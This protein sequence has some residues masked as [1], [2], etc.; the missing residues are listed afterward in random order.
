MSALEGA[1]NVLAAARA[2][3][4]QATKE[5]DDAN[6]ALERAGAAFNAGPSDEREEECERCT[7]AVSKAKRY[8]EARAKALT[9]ATRSYEQQ[10]VLRARDDR[11]RLLLERRVMLTRING[12]VQALR[13]LYETLFKIVSAIEAELSSDRDRVSAINEL[14]AVIQSREEYAPLDPGLLRLAVGLR[15]ARHFA[16]PE[17]PRGVSFSE[18]AGELDRVFAPGDKSVI[19]QRL[20]RAL[21]TFDACM[22]DAELGRW[23][24]LQPAPRSNDLS[25]G[26]ERLRDAQ[27]V[28]EALEAAT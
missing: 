24:S 13:E 10:R 20:S 11:D 5:L 8:V 7:R 17:V 22:G 26:A 21:T 6:V 23:L 28:L 27:R 19:V 14:G 2:A 4:Q 15:L 9:E 3:H 1:R 16:L 12:Q 18:F 25:R